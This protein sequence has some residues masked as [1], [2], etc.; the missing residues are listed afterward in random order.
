MYN[1]VLN[2]HHR[3]FIV[4]KSSGKHILID[5]G[6]DVS[7]WPTSSKYLNVFNN[8]NKKSQRC[9]FQLFAHNG[10]RITAYGLERITIDLGF[11]QPFTYSFIIAESGYP[12]IGADFLSHFHLLPDPIKP[13]DICTRIH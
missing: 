10:T 3:L 12:I 5:T 8:N 4:D 7:I 11:G 2:N 13:Q 9:N 1:N 6:S